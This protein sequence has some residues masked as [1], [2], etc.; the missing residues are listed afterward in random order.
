MQY[1]D[2][3]LFRG[4][5]IYKFTDFLLFLVVIALKQSSIFIK[6][7]HVWFATISFS[8]ISLILLNKCLVLFLQLKGGRLNIF[9]SRSPVRGT[10]S[11][12]GGGR[13]S[14]T[15]FAGDDATLVRLA[16][17]TLNHLTTHL[18]S[19][20]YAPKT[21]KWLVCIFYNLRVAALHCNW[22]TAAAGRC[23]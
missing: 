12:W 4:D 21:A 9:R 11:Q 18:H 23:P 6:W 19:T 7:S 20:L 2:A 13:S 22:A 15:H 17:F 8:L 1:P 10:A 5:I 14:S 16:L 3:C